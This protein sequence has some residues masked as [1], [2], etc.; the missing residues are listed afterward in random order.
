MNPLLSDNVNL[1]LHN[2][3]NTRDCKSQKSH[4]AKTAGLQAGGQSRG[5]SF[6]KPLAYRR[7]VPVIARDCLLVGGI[8]IAFGLFNPDLL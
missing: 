8:S 5:R 7:T 6:C 2:I 1:C 4:I 3:P